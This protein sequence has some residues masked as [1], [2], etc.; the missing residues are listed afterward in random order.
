MVVSTFWIVQG[1]MRTVEQY[2]D[3]VIKLIDYWTLKRMDRDGVP[4]L[5]PYRTHYPFKEMEETQTD[6]KK[7]R[8]RRYVHIHI[9]QYF[10]FLYDVIRNI[11]IFF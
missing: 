9:Y 4:L 6:S 10:S 1:H 3:F 8:V 5:D 2:S 7:Q 11:N